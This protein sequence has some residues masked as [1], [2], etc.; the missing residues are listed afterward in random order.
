THILAV[1]SEKTKESWWVP[2][3]IGIATE[4]E[5]TIASYLISSVR[6]PEYLEAW[7]RLRDRKDLELYCDH[8]TKPRTLL[9]NSASTSYGKR[10]SYSDAFH[11]IL[12]KNLGQ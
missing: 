11:Y 8:L 4:K 7:P 6:L 5:H 12:K 3:E 1:L 9:E 2:F 10:V